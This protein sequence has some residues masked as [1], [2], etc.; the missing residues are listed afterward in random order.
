MKTIE[1]AIVELRGCGAAIQITIDWDKSP[2]VHV[3]DRS[4]KLHQTSGMDVL[5][6]LQS[7]ILKLSVLNA[8]EDSVT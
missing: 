7:M 8:E 5:T 6:A 4:G 1:E 3:F 2:T